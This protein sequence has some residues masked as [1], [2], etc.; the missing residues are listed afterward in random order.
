MVASKPDRS[1]HGDSDAPLP[2]TI[3]SDLIC[4]WC[5][6]GKRRFETALRAPGMSNTTVA[7]TAQAPMARH[8]SAAERR[9]GASADWVVSVKGSNTVPIAQ[10]REGTAQVTLTRALT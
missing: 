4:P 5:Y 3:Y 6:V 10:G 1:A 9:G 8:S 2:V 7:T